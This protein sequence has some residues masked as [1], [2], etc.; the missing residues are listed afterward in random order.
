ARAR[1][2]APSTRA[3]G[4]RPLADREHGA[5]GRRRG[6]RRDRALVP[7]PRRPEPDLAREGDRERL[8]AR[9]DLLGSV[10]GDR[11]AG[12][13][14]RARH[15][16]LQPHRAGARGRAQPAPAGSAPRRADLPAAAARRPERRVAV[17]ALLAVEDLHAW[18]E[19]PG[20][21]ALHAV[22]GVSLSVARGERLGLVGESGC[23]KTTTAL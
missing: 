1:E 10:V 21:G 18:F 8:P 6:L 12:R 5:D 19:L 22:Q 7:G 16:G 20:G 4:G 14:R 23:G 17:S 2:D 3:P 13:A 9:G 11:P 15:P